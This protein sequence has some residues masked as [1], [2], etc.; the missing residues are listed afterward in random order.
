MS[1][2]TALVIGA[3][4]LIGKELTRLLLENSAYATVIA[5][6]RRPTGLASGAA[7]L[8]E[9]DFDFSNWDALDSR[10]PADDVFCCLGTT[11]KKAGS[12]AAFRTVDFDYPLEFARR[13]EASGSKRFLI[14]S[15]LGADAKSMVFYSR[16]KGEIEAAVTEL[17]GFESVHVLRPSLLLGD[18]G[19]K[20]PG[21]E[22][23]SL[24]SG[25]VSWS[26]IGPARKYRPIRAETVARAMMRLAAREEPG[27]FIHESDELEAIGA[28]GTAGSGA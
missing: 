26:L 11:I 7:R 1:K 23:A 10:L 19:E 9:I 18:R 6:V 22:L 5:P 25:L 28:P 8:E 14:V 21:E 27:R 24:A 17:A 3:T 4:G 15:S 12:Q 20:R 13:A 16:V 2:K